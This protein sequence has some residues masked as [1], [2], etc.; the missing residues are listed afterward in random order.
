MFKSN[1]GVTLIM[2]V[3]TVIIIVILLGAIITTTIELIKNTRNNTIK[4]NMILIKAEVQAIYD[5]YQFTE[6]ESILKLD[7]SED[8]TYEKEENLSEY[9]ITVETGDLWYS[10]DR[11]TLAYLGLDTN[12]LPDNET[13]Y[14]VN[15]STGEII[16]TKGVEAS[17]GTIKYTLTD[18]LQ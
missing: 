3:I 6:D 12:M 13:Y 7:K 11:D 10:W 5:E 4:T 9:E 15:Y 17:D 2:L 16:Y 18:M 14:F 8:D 1:K